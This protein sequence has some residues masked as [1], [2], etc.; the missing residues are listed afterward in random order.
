V[1]SWVCLALALTA[2]SV[3]LDIEAADGLDPVERQALSAEIEYAVAVA[4]GEGPSAE[5]PIR[6]AVRA[7]RVSWRL[8][9]TIDR[10]SGAQLVA[11]ETV[12]VSRDPKTWRAPIGDAVKR[13]LPEGRSLA[14]GKP[15][16]TAPP[17]VVATPPP[18][19]IAPPAMITPELEAPPMIVQQEERTHSKLIP[20]LA[21]GGGVA[22]GL[23]GVK[24]VMNASDAIDA[25]MFSID[26]DEI[27]AQQRAV[28]ENAVLGSVML[29][30]GSA[31]L[32]TGLVL[33]LSD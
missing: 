24:F 17:P 6:L 23:A 19:A 28:F 4:T 21:M 10:K 12:A 16:A 9:V 25:T 8:Q 3:G 2:G 32:V 30:L 20:L 7:R 13:L 26:Q 31:A 18:A 15:A 5:N 27:E 29:S 22:A 11:R 1:V 14:T 33:L